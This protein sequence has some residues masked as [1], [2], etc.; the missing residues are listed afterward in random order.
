[1]LIPKEKKKEYEVKSSHFWYIKI[2]TSS[3][4]E[5]ILQPN[6]DVVKYYEENWKS[7]KPMWVAYYRNDMIKYKTNTNNIAEAINSSFKKWIRDKLK[8]HVA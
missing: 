1:M 8:C 5:I 2:F 4:L 6:P 7:I 3:I